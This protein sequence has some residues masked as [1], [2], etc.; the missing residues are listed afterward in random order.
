MEHKT[1]E[2][3]VKRILTFDVEG[4][5]L[6][7][8]SRKKWMEVVKSGLKSWKKSRC[9]ENGF[10]EKDHCGRGQA[11][12]GDLYGHPDEHIN[13]ISKICHAMSV[14]FN[15]D[16]DDGVQCKIFPLLLCLLYLLAEF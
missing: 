2:V 1:E 6:P 7:G 5:R 14:P 9:P 4:N 11:N 10:V 12:L 3:W 8:R 15:D 13:N 16:N